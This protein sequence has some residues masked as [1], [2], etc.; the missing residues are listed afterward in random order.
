MQQEAATQMEIERVLFNLWSK[1][2]SNG[3][4][5]V[6]NSSSQEDT[7]SPS[8]ECR[9]REDDGYTISP[10]KFN[11]RK[12]NKNNDSCIEKKTCCFCEE[13][14]I[15]GDQF[16]S[17]LLKC[18]ERKRRRKKRQTPKK[19]FLEESSPRMRVRTPGR[20]MPWE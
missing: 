9:V 13:T 20:R 2:G 7:Q 14:L 18:K 15:G 11:V 1:I 12:N 16:S 5:T 3:Q 19:T 8:K 17:H 10:Q 6:A 4:A